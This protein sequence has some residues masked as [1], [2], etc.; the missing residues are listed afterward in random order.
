MVGENWDIEQYK[1]KK[2]IDSKKKKRNVEV[3]FVCIGGM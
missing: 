2:Y 3:L 1:E